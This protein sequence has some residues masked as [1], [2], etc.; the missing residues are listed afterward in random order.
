MATLQ[1]NGASY[2]VTRKM[3][4]FGQLEVG[5][6]V[7]PLLASGIGE[8]APLIIA[9]RNEGLNL[10]SMPMDRLGQIITPVS[11]ELAK[12][13]AD[14]R[15]FIIGS[16][17]TTVDRKE[18]GEGKGWAPVWNVEARRAMFEDVNSDFT[19][20]MR[21]VAFVLQETFAAFLPASLSGLSGGARA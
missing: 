10:E 21:I 2:R 11:R 20:M 6:K 16:C 7:M 5:T 18:D 12:M 8:L 19:V 4:A 1:L 17:L 15:R 3:D 9:L 13:T 14:D